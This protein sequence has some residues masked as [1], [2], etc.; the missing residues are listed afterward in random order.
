MMNDD[1]PVRASFIIHHSAFIIPK[2]ADARKAARPSVDSYD[3]H[4]DGEVADGGTRAD[5]T[6][7]LPPRHSTRPAVRRLLEREAVM[8]G[9]PR[10]IDPG[11]ITDEALLAYARGEDGEGAAHIARCPAC[12]AEARAYARLEPLLSAGLYRRSCPDTL[13]LGEYALDTLDPDARRQVA[14]HLVDCPHC[15]AE[16]RDVRAFL[17]EPDPPAPLG[18]VRTLRRILARRLEPLAP[19]LAGLRGGPAESVTYETDD[20]S[21]T[22]DVQPGTRPAERVIAGLVLASGPLAGAPATLHQDDRLLQSETIDDLDAFL[23]APVPPGAYRVELTLDD[24][25]IVLDPVD[26]T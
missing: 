25:V 8:T 13:I 1:S 3:T 15:L 11:D 17:A 14:V 6:P 7:F 2:G 19:A 12:L 5:R 24:A 21:V 26:A 23:F 9:E 16:S 20:V 10:C 22:L 4:H 18:V